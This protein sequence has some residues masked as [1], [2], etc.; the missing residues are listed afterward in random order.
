MRGNKTPDRFFCTQCGQEGIPIVR[1]K[2]KEREAGHLKNLYCIYCKKE[3]NH[4]EIREKSQN[5]TLEDFQ[6]EFELGRFVNG[7]R[8]EL[9]DLLK[10]SN[11]NCIYNID[12]NCWNANFSYPCRTSFKKR[13]C[14]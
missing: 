11:S 4:V 3:T 7:N 6:L 10:C 1:P 5:Y 14:F 8:T 12:G 13:R 9:K 2:C